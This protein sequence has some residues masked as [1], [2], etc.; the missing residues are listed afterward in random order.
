MSIGEKIKQIRLESNLTQKE[1]AEKIGIRHPQKIR[2]L[3]VDEI[4]F[5]KDEVLFNA[6]S[7]IGLSSS[8]VSGLTINYGVYITTSSIGDKK[9][10]CENYCC[11]L[12]LSPY[13]SS[14]SSVK[15]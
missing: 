15:T 4:P 10:L 14:S 11:L 7:K 1:F 2:I 9:I 3:N 12:L 5:P 13:H 8:M 6:L